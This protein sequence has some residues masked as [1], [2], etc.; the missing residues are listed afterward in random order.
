M[1]LK[2]LIFK[3]DIEFESKR[4]SQEQMF[5]VRMEVRYEKNYRKSYYTNDGEEIIPEE[6]VVDHTF[7]IF[8]KGLTIDFKPI[9]VIVGDNGCGK[10]SF[11]DEIAFPYKDLKN[12][13]TTDSKEEYEK[14]IIKGWIEN[15]NRKLSLLKMPER[16]IVEKEIHKELFIKGYRDQNTDMSGYMPPKNLLASLDMNTYSNG[17]CSLDFLKSLLQVQNSLIVLDEPETSL[18][19]KSQYKVYDLIKEI[20]KMNQ[21]IL[22]THAEI[23]MNLSDV[24]YDF[25]KKKYTEIKQYLQEQ[26]P[27]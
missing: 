17:E 9:T 16:V 21:I 15:D 8:K 14:K 6:K 22:I 23:L 11:I 5:D 4:T 7:T 19:I 1:F 12:S 20:G 25:E 24:V 26:M 18:S 27:K 13:W 3:K 2:S 10:T